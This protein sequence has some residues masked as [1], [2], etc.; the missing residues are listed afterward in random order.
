MGGAPIFYPACPYSSDGETSKPDESHMRRLCHRKMVQVA[1]LSWQCPLGHTGTPVNR[2]LSSRIKLLD[3][4]GCIDV[5]FFDTV[6]RFIFGCDA[7]H[8]AHQ[9]GSGIASLH[10]MLLKRASWR[11]FR[12]KLLSKREMWQ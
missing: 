4:T 6:G 11:R 9:V 7:D 5:Q 3:H 12:L 10:R 8:F 1:P 2:Y